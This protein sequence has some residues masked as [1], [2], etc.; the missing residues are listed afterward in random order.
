MNGLVFYIGLGLGLALAA[1]LR[2]FLPALLAGALGSAGDLGVSF[3]HSGYA[4]LQSDWWLLALAAAFVVAW[5][6]QLVLGVA[7]L[8]TARAIR[9][10]RVLA[11]GAKPLG[12]ENVW[13]WMSAWRASRFLPPQ[14]M[15]AIPRSEKSAVRLSAQ[16]AATTVLAASSPMFIANTL[17]KGTAVVLLASRF[18]FFMVIFGV[19][20]LLSAYYS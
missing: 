14:G 7:R 1:G 20:Q 5:A 11:E 4:F 12:E 18:G 15:E 6:L 16:E 9:V 19:V 13:K 2:P 17:V 3:A 10:S 8:D